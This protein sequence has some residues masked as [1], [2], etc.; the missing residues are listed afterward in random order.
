MEFCLT[1]EDFLSTTVMNVRL[2][3][4]TFFSFAIDPFLLDYLPFER[5]INE[6]TEAIGKVPRFLLNCKDIFEMQ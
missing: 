4:P 2:S 6:V 3:H 1:P 5:A